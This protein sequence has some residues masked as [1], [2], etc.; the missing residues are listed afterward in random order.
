ML[1]AIL[2]VMDRGS[3]MPLQRDDLFDKRVGAEG[4]VPSVDQV[5]GPIEFQG[6]QT[7]DLQVRTAA[8][9]KDRLADPGPFSEVDPICTIQTVR[10]SHD[11]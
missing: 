1:R 5:F 9:A 4:Q 7:C 8:I 11:R 10:E 2:S 3:G 6:M